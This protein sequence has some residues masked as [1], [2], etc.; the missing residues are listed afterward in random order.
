MRA[1]DGRAHAEGA[2]D[3]SPRLPAPSGYADEL[4][5][6]VA[7]VARIDAWMEIAKPGDVFVYATRA[8]LPIASAGAKRMYE[9]AKRDLVCLTRPRSTLD[10]SVFNYRATRTSKSTALSKPMRAMLSA[11]LIDAEPALIDALLPVLTR[12]AR[13]G[14][15]CPTNN[16]LASRSGLAVDQ[17]DAALAA[18]VLAGLIRIQSLPRPTMRRIVIV[19]TGEQTG[20]AA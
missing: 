17:I 7:S 5:S 8:T 18:L 16:Q 19:A 20:V 6:V 9:L 1:A 14:R 15:P 4:P 12:L 2:G 11:P 13:F 3:N 10:P